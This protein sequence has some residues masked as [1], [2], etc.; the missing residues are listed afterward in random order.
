ME[1]KPVT[2]PAA[3]DEFKNLLQDSGLPV[4]DLRIDTDFLLAGYEEGSL[5]ATGALEFHFPFALL[6]SLSVRL[7][8]RGKSIGS[9]MVDALLSE[10][11]ERKVEAVYLLTESAKDFFLKKG[12]EEV[13][14][15]HVPQEIKQTQEFTTLCSS[16]A[17]VMRFTLS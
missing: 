5:I 3:F 7:G 14:R 10:A 11:R 8:T 12:F 17:I 6:R 9:Q 13:N 1:K 15:D 2:A 16:S 4:S